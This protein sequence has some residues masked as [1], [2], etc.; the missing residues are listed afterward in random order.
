MADHV[1]RFVRFER[2][3]PPGSVFEGLRPLGPF[4]CA[5]CGE[6]WP[7]YPLPLPAHEREGYGHVAHQPGFNARLRTAL[8]GIPDDPAPGAA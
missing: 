6:P 1:H 7:G 5:D 3:P 4:A 2:T 8:A